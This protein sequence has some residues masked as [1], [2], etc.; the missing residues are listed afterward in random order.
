MHHPPI[1]GKA[2][3]VA[4]AWRLRV[5]ALAFVSLIGATACRHKGP[6][7]EEDIDF[8]PEPV[9]IHVINENYLDM[10]VYYVANSVTRRLGMVTGNGKGD[11]MVP[12]SSVASSSVVMVGVPIGG[13]G[14]AVSGGLNVGV[15]QAISFRIAS[16]LRQSVAIVQEP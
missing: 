7:T 6:Q 15:G 8:R 3:M 13:S 10:N 2:T 14:R 12:W 5:A 1:R 16:V 9:P 11:F 4:Q